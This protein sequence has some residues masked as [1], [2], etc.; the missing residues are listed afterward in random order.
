MH[1]IGQASYP[2]QARDV[3]VINDKNRHS[4]SESRDLRTVSVTFDYQK[5]KIKRW[6]TFI[7]RGFQKL[8][9]PRALRGQTAATQS[10]LHM[11]EKNYFNAVALIQEIEKTSRERF[12]CWQMLVDCHFRHLVLLLSRAYDGYLRTHDEALERMTEATS[13][14]QKKFRQEVDL[15]QLAKDMG[16]SQRTFYRLFKR[17]TRQSPLSYLIRLRIQ[18]ACDQLR[19]TDRPITP[20][21]FDSGFSDSNYFAREFRKIIGESPTAYRGRWAD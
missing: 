17:A 14:L 18:Y 2:I 11:D 13:F 16:M 8:F 7:L 20:I 10:R 21:A 4:Y 3:F 6:P 1:H 15:N 12:P 19:N 9:N 5:L